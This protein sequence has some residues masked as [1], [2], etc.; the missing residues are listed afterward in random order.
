VTF[1]AQ[2]TDAAAVLRARANPDGG[3]SPVQGT[4]EPE[5]TAVAA[6]ALTADPAGEAARSWLRDHQRRDGTWAAISGLPRPTIA[7]TA[8]G[9]L[10][11]DDGEQ[12]TRA[13]DALTRLRAPVLKGTTPP[14]EPVRR[15]WGWTPR[16][17]G[18]VEPT[19]WATLA[20]K[21][22]RPT[23][24]VLVED[25][26]RVLSD[27]ECVGGGWNYGNRTVY[28]QPL[29][30]YVLTTAIALIGL[31]NTGR[32]ELLARGTRLLRARWRDERGGLTT[33]LTLIALRLAAGDDDVD[34]TAARGAL[35]DDLDEIVA[36]GDNVA[37]AW[38]SVA[39]SGDLDALRIRS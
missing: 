29:A 38:T 34:A 20:L 21:R 7:P 13:V 6:L 36:F 4:S 12:R 31:Q 8:L 32:G 11:L 22:L 27:R 24:R 16:M 9:A 37:L 2:G 14:N 26:E 30:P 5:P 33:A 19:S 15:G 17:F 25:G 18:W 3:F 1:A 35:L 10:V 23:E 28:G 39:L